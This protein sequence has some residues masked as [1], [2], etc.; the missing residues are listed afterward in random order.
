[1]SF[2]KY[3]TFYKKIQNFRDI[4]SLLQWDSEVMMPTAGR[5]SRSQQ[6]AEMSGLIHDA[7]TGTEFRSLID[8]AE[9]ELEHSLDNPNIMKLKKEIDVL[10]ETLEKQS[11]LPTE[12]VAELSQ[13]T[14]IAQSKWEEAKT[15]NDFSLFQNT[16]SELVDLAIRQAEYYG[17]NTERYDALLDDYEKGA[18]AKNLSSLFDSLKVEL[19]PIVAKSKSYPNPF[20]KE[21]SIENQEKFCQLIP[22]YLG[23]PQNQS[24][25]DRSSH[26]FSTSLGSQ[27]KRITTR[28]DLKDPLSS[29]FGVIHETGHA[30]YEIGLSEMDEAPNPLAEYLTLGMHESQSRLWENQVGRSESF[31]IYYYPIALEFW[32]LKEA[33]LLFSD[34]MNYIKSV[35]RTKIRVEADPITYNLHIILRFEIERDLISQKIKTKDLPEIWNSKMKENFG[36][37]IE[38]PSEGVLQDIHWSMAAFGYFPTYALG[39]IYSA[40]LYHAFLKENQS[41]EK[42]LARTGDTSN[43]LNWLRKNIHYSGKFYSVDDLLIQ[44]T[45]ET[46]NSR[47]LIESLTNF[48]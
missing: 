2:A 7:F 24:R 8:L 19:K 28:Y 17:Y 41:F 44:T 3:R 6:I 35:E 39:N 34:F 18:K 46:A 43:L 29:V 12:F 47:F 25:L 11:K 4:Q 13:K 22:A 40:Q 38:N 23:L 5:I 36:L 9:S 1:M 48:H 20:K 37:V 31:W 10:K 33:D 21:V 26:P 16:L 42:N 14:N 32:K 15:K 30:L 27:D 45:G